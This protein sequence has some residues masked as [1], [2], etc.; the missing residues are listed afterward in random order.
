ML[1]RPHWLPYIFIKLSLVF[2]S[3]IIAGLFTELPD[4]D[5]PF[6]QVFLFTVIIYV[7]AVIVFNQYFKKKYRFFMGIIA[8][9]AIFLSG[10]IRVEQTRPIDDP[11]FLSNAN[12]APGYYRAIVSGDSEIKGTWTRTKVKITDCYIDGQW[13]KK[14]IQIYLYQR[15]GKNHQPISI[16]D[17]ILV[18][19]S[20]TPVKGPMNPGAFD[21]RKFL[22]QHG[23]S[24]Q[25]YASSREIMITGHHEPNFFIGLSYVLKHRILSILR[26]RIQDPNALGITIALIVGSKEEL[27]YEMKQTYAKAGVMH[28]LAVSGLHVGIVYLVLLNS[29]GKIRSR[30]WGK[31]IFASITLTILWFYALL[32]G[33][34]PSVLRA[35]TMF[36]MIVIARSFKRQTNI[37]NSIAASAFILLCFDPWLLKSV[38]FQLSYL[39]VFG[40]V[41]IQPGIYTVLNLKNRL[42]DKIW[43][44]TTVSVAAQLATFPLGLFYFQQFPSYFI[45]SNLLVMPL[46]FCILYLGWILVLCNA[47]EL[48][49]GFLARL[50]EYLIDFNNH[51]LSI[52][53]QLPM[54][55]IHFYPTKWQ[56]ILIYLSLLGILSAI[57][58]RNAKYILFSFVLIL[59]LSISE[60]NH[61]TKQNKV[62]QIVLYSI[63]Q[64]SI[65]DIIKGHRVQEH[66]MIVP[67]SRPEQLDQ[68]IKINRLK[69]GLPI[70]RH[71]KD[72]NHGHIIPVISKEDY[73]L[74]S[75]YNIKIL[76]IRKSS[77]IRSIDPASLKIDFLIIENESIEDV[78]QLLEIFHCKTLVIGSSNSIYYAKKILKEMENLNIRCHSIPHQGAFTID[79]TNAS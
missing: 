44:L 33:L 30:K 54:S 7:I 21:Y 65:T 79:L 53:S 69:M 13:L 64:S 19:G 23:I 49:A 27:S 35:V 74:I 12:K 16:G 77:V 76:F 18:K 40:I 5:L 8:L 61:I 50:L 57:H 39:A 45:L 67:D 20:P 51:F 28:V 34:S 14:D 3:G 2:I 60:I 41:Y 46:I 43:E 9:L 72:H 4:L 32:T 63:P 66:H 25:H 58:L 17:Q 10:W 59:S 42:L 75:W 6:K 1:T 36:S 38:G 31:L 71:T 48:V 26:S 62:R 47:S 22:L 78:R 70:D 29:L 73:D 55:T 56:T 11:L 24:Y 52:V 37:Y 68:R 15:I